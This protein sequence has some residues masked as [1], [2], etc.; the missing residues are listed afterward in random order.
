MRVDCSEFGTYTGA[1]AIRGFQLD[2]VGAPATCAKKCLPT[3]RPV[4]PAYP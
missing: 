4:R 2:F 1:F 3:L